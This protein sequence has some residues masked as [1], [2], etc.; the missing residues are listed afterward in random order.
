MN[1]NKIDRR[2]LNEI[3]ILNSEKKFPCFVFS[4]FPSKTREVLK[5]RNIHIV[6]EYL[7]INSFY[8]LASQK[9]I[10]SLS[11]VEAVCFI[12]SLSVANAMMYVSKQI[13][14]TSSLDTGG[15]GVGVAFI[16]T[17]LAPHCDFLLGKN[18]VEVFKDFVASKKEMYDDNGHGTFV[19]GVCAGSGALS[20]F[21][22]SGVAPR[23][24]IFSLKALDGK[25]EASANK[26]LDAMQWVYENHKK[27]N[28][29]VVCM[30]FGSEPLGRNDPIMLGAEALWKDGV[31]VVAAAGN[32]GPE[33]Q[34]IKSPGISN[35]IITVGGIDDNR[36]DNASYNKKYF[37]IANFSSRGPAFRS[38]KPDVVAPSVDITSCGIREAYTTLSGT[39][40]A[41]P[42]IAGIAALLLEKFPTATP[43]QIKSMLLKCCQPLGFEMYQEGYGLPCLDRMK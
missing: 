43:K 42:M 41:T 4:Y 7:F 16:D 37:E 31:V 32:S 18:R 23:C 30:S 29:G 19:C 39:S 14:S 8:C 15:E 25:G 1:V 10:F 21:K 38:V 5:K 24:R 36:Y 12:S 27:H 3:A 2:L 11:N 35:H 40:V 20:K 33:Y 22:F 26:I 6:D 28:I 9:E 13:L 17:G 34:T